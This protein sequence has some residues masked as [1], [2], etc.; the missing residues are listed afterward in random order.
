MDAPQHATNA[1]V[2]V[3]YDSSS[4][5]R[6]RG[7]AALLACSLLSVGVGVAVGRSTAPAA[8]APA[9]S[10]AAAVRTQVRL[11]P[12]LAR[13]AQIR[14]ER[15]ARARV[16]SSLQLAGSVDFDATRTAEV[17]GRIAGRITRILVRPGDVVRAGDALAEIES[18]QLGEAIAQYFSAQARLIAARQTLAREGS[19]ASQR[20]TTAQAHE[21][22]RANAEALQAEV[23]GAEARLMAMGI[24]RTEL[25]SML[26]ASSSSRDRARVCAKRVTS[27]ATCAPRSVA[28]SRAV[29]ASAWIIARSPCAR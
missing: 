2:G 16:S 5:P 8:S 22:A 17:G 10:A 18:A 19:L 25:P 20:L 14:V 6:S 9:A 11:D 28:L 15:A 26:S 29:A 4:P 12:E 3:P 24:A 13:R 7:V 27:R 1:S 21:E 23:R